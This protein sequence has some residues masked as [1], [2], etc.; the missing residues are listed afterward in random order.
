MLNF[1]TK[2]LLAAALA[3]F[4][5][6]LPVHA[7]DLTIQ[8]AGATFPL[9][10]YTKWAEAYNKSQTGVKVDYQGIGSG[11]GIKGITDKTFQFGASDAPISADQEKADPGILHLPTVA[12]PEAVIYNLPGVEGLKMNGDVLAGIY[13]KNIRKWNDPK[14]AAINPGVNLRRIARSPSPTG[15]TDRAPRTFFPITFPR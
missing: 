2:S 8:G 14:I 9:P 1:C 3:V 13:L 7:A 5:W 15:P 12:G 11:G 10:L 6:S 4:A